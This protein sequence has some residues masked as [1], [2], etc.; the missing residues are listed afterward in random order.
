MPVAEPRTERQTACHFTAHLHLGKESIAF[1][2]IR[3][4]PHLTV[5]FEYRNGDRGVAGLIRLRSAA[6]PMTVVLQ[7]ANPADP[8]VPTVWA[9]ALIGFTS[10]TCPELSQPSRGPGR[11]TAR[12]DGDH[13]RA[14]NP[15]RPASTKRWSDDLT[16]RGARDGAMPHLV[17]AHRRRLN[18]GQT[19]S[20]KAVTLARSIGIELASGETWVRS[21]SRGADDLSDA[22]FDWHPPTD[23]AEL[24]RPMV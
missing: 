15:V 17:V 4:A 6:D 20:T 2:P 9:L 18:D 13:K 3:P 14:G 10:L 8:L 21:H 11:R 7:L 19:A 22:H 1:K 5:P 23:I 12:S 24:M 16:L